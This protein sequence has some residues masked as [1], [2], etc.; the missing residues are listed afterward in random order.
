M[1]KPIIQ[2]LK[3]E[4]DQVLDAKIDASVNE[5]MDWYQSAHAPTKRQIIDAINKLTDKLVEIQAEERKVIEIAD[6]LEKSRTL[7]VFKRFAYRCR[8]AEGR[9]YEK[10]KNIAKATNRSKA[11]VKHD[12]LI[13]K[14]LKLIYSVVE[15]IPGRKKNGWVRRL[16]PLGQKVYGVL[17]NRYLKMKAETIEPD[18]KNITDKFINEI[19]GKI[20]KVKP[21]TIRAKVEAKPSPVTE[22]ISNFIPTAAN[23]DFIKEQVAKMHQVIDGET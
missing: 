7:F 23:R 18:I 22:G 19:F 1:T 3:N 21:V 6:K 15:F 4:L 20:T 17:T 16:T 11:S 5:L 12:L 13:F 9:S 8:C 2:K 14:H 10:F